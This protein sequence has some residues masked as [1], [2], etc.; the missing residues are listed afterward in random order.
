M[1]RPLIWVVFLLLLVTACSPV[2]GGFEGLPQPTAIATQWVL[3]VDDSEP[4]EAV[5]VTPTPQR[6]TLAPTE[7]SEP[8]L[9]G[10]ACGEVFCALAWPGWLARPIGE[11]FT[12]TIDRSYP[13]G[14]TANGNFDLHYGVEFPNGHGTPVLAAQDGEVIFAGPD[15]QTQLGPFVG[16]YG[17]V[18]ILL[19]T[20]LLDGAQDVYTL[21]AHLSEIEVEVGDRVSA[22]QEIGRVGATGAADGSHL[23]FEVRVAH[24]D[25]A[26]TT[27]PVL[28]FAPL[29]DTEHQATVTLAGHI[30]DRGGNPV[31]KFPLTLEKLSTTGGVEA[32]YYPVTYYPA[33]VNGHPVMGENFVVP[34]IPPGDYR[35]A[36]ISGRM[37]EFFFTLEPGSLGFISVQLD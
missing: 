33:G 13:Y 8:E 28:W 2:E 26:S 14:S 10:L 21:Y 1:R 5:A 37:Y 27:N 35:L 3:E 15:S 4:A 25:Y 34:D 7:V 36:F 23:H 17:Q 32:H 22:G 19:H 18:V 6:P 16:F 12:R 31:S 9:T 20:G 24:N 30:L 29:D 11:G